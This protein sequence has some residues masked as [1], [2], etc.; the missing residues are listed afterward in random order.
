MRKSP[1]CSNRLWKWFLPIVPLF[2]LSSC[3]LIVSTQPTTL[4]GATIVFVAI[5]D[6]GSLVAS[7]HITVVDVDGDWREHGLTTRDGSFR[8]EVRSGIPRVRATVVPPAGYT[9][10]RSAQWPRELDVQAGSTVRVEIRVT[11]KAT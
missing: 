10:A 7:L 3:L 4:S 5:D 6:R 8:C 11:A 9:I 2:T 1:H